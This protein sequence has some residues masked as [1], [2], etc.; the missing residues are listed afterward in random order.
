MTTR[1]W[2]IRS[3]LQPTYHPL[4]LLVCRE[5]INMIKIKLPIPY[6]SFGQLFM[7]RSHMTYIPV[8]SVPALSNCLLYLWV[9]QSDPD[10]PPSASSPPPALPSD[11]CS[12]PQPRPSHAVTTQK[13]QLCIFSAD[14]LYM[15]VIHRGK[16]GEV[17]YSWWHTYCLNWNHYVWYHV[18]G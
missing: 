7:H 16:V 10:L 6:T 4:N 14:I 17:V 15:I 2:Y 11:E 9:P 8:C 18:R 5:K 12:P 13:T 1:A 3:Q